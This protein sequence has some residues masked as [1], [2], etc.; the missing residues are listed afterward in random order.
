MQA[1]RILNASRCPT[2]KTLLAAQPEI[3]QEANRCPA[4]AVA[5]ENRP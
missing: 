4:Q 3:Q 2:E 1:M 5:N